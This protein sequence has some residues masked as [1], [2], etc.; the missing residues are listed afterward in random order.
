MSSSNDCQSGGKL[1]SHAVM[2]DTPSLTSEADALFVVATSA[3]S[4]VV[5]SDVNIEHLPWL[6]LLV[7]FRVYVGAYRLQRRR[8]VLV[9]HRRTVFVLRTV[10]GQTCADGGGTGDWSRVIQSFLHR[11][12]FHTL[13]SYFRFQS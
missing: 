13:V 5:I 12:H 11:E 7:Q 1:S 4:I 9:P 3:T 8:S 10:A 2:L 6:R